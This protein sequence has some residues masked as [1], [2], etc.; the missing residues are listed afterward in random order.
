M[1]TCIGVVVI[2]SRQW[3]S[4]RRLF[5]QVIA[6]IIGA[7]IFAV[8]LVGT[9][10]PPPAPPFNI[11]PFITV[12]WLVIGIL[13]AVFFLKNKP[14]VFSAIGRVFVDV[15]SGEDLEKMDQV[16]QSGQTRTV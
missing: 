16:D 4:E 7:A 13:L 14:E 9:F 1:V 8:P 12:A 5:P 10:Y 3:R 15:G 11:F 6:P 2:F